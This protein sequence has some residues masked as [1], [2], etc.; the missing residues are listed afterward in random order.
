MSYKL[1]LKTQLIY[2]VS[3][4]LITFALVYL[5]LKQTD[6]IASAITGIINFIISGYYTN[7][8]CI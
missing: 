4:F 1:N 3:A 6:F 8:K 2:G 5:I 7:Q